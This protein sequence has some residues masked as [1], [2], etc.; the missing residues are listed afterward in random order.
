[1]D[2]FHEK[3]RL[4]GWKMDDLWVPYPP[5]VFST[6][7]NCMCP[8]H[9]VCAHE[10]VREG[11]QNDHEFQVY[12]GIPHLQTQPEIMFFAN[13]CQLYIPVYPNIYQSLAVNILYQTL[14]STAPTWFCTSCTANL[15]GGV[16]EKIK[17]L[18]RSHSTT[19]ARVDATEVPHS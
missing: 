5:C 9:Y 7:R 14:S 18:S 3:I 11:C 1:M 13:V 6:N 8:H 16:P 19:L 17:S 12:H 15:Q 4:N 2:S 10:D